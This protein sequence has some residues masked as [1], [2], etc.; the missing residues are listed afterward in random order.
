MNGVICLNIKKLDLR[1]LSLIDLRLS[2]VL[3]SSIKLSLAFQSSLDFRSSLEFRAIICS[4]R[5]S[6]INYQTTLLYLEERLWFSLQMSFI[7]YQLS[8]CETGGFRVLSRFDAHLLS[9]FEA[10][11]SGVEYLSQNQ[12]KHGRRRGRTQVN[13]TEGP[14]ILWTSTPIVYILAIPM[15]LITLKFLIFYHALLCYLGSNKH[16]RWKY[17]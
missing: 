11:L 15:L 5:T 10:E 6:P 3:G 8:S 4:Q 14:H 13:T 7:S 17:I 12:H 1:S 16:Q 9:L 2:H